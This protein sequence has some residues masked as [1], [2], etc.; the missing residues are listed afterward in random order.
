DVRA[1]RGDGGD[2]LALVVDLVA[3][4]AVAAEVPQVDRPF[5]QL[6]DLVAGVGEVGGGDDGLD[7]GQGEGLADVDLL[8]AAV[9]DGAAQDAAV[10]QARHLHV[11][12]VNGPTRDLVHA[13]VA[14]GARADDLEI[15]GSSRA[16]HHETHEIHEKRTKK[17]QRFFLTS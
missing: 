15:H 1:D 14:D 9:R 6:R 8:D 17:G 11:G 16:N 2:G 3:R 13:V 4:Q 10:Q 7:A 12:A 5:A